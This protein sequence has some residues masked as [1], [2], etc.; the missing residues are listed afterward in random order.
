MNQCVITVP[1][2]KGSPQPAAIKSVVRVLGNSSGKASCNG[3]VAGLT[4]GATVGFV[5]VMVPWFGETT[6]FH[7]P[8]ALYGNCFISEK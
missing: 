3:G 6:C 4:I 7:L 5:A 8:Q 1:F 2:T